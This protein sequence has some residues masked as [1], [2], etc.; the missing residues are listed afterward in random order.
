[1]NSALSDSKE[2][3]MHEE[4]MERMQEKQQ[5][6]I[7]ARGGD[8]DDDEWEIFFNYYLNLRY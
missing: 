4:M 3:T 2:L 5:A 8:V 1:M 7:K 6:E